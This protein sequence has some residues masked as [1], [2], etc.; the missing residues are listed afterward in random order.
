M[1]VI[2]LVYLF[3]YL[4]TFFL[5]TQESSIQTDYCFI[6]ARHEDVTN[7]VANMTQLPSSLTTRHVQLPDLFIS[8]AEKNH[9]TFLLNGTVDKEVLVAVISLLKR[10]NIFN[11]ISVKLI[12]NE[13]KSFDVHIEASLFPMVKMVNIH[14]FLL[15]KER[16]IALYGSHA[17][18]EFSPVQ[19]QKGIQALEQWFHAQGYYAV[20]IEDDITYVDKDQVQIDLSIRQGKQ[21]IVSA[22][23][24][25]IEGDLISAS[26]Q[27]LTQKLEKMVRRALKRTYYTQNR[28]DDYLETVRAYLNKQGYVY[29]Q[30]SYDLKPRYKTKAVDIQVQVNIYQTKRFALVGCSD[31]NRSYLLDTLKSFNAIGSIVPLAILSEE[32]SRFYKTRGYASPAITYYEEADVIYFVIDEG[33]PT[34]YCIA[35]T[36]FEDLLSEEYKSAILKLLP[37]E[38]TYHE[39]DTIKQQIITQLREYGFWQASCTHKTVHIH[40]ERNTIN[41]I[42]QSGEQRRINRISFTHF[43]EL[44]NTKLFSPFVSSSLMPLPINTVQEQAKYIDTYLRNKGYVYAKAK[45]MMVNDTE[46]EW[47]FEGFLEPV[48]FGKV[49]FEGRSTGIENCITKQL[50]FAE[51]NIWDSSLLY[52]SY[53]RLM[54]LDIFDEISLQPEDLQV[55]S[56]HKNC[57]IRYTL[58]KTYEARSRLG[59]LL[60]GQN[61]QYTTATIKLG[62]NF[63]WRNV[64]NRADHILINADYSRYKRDVVLRYYQPWFMDWSMQ[65][66]YELYS[67][68]YSQALTPGS[69]FN[70]YDLYQN[71]FLTACKIEREDWNVGIDLG[72]ETM[73]LQCISFELAQKINF[74]PRLVGKHVPYIFS[75][76]TLFGQRLD[77]KINPHSGY[78]GL[79]TAKTMCPLSLKDGAFLRVLGEIA[80]FIPLDTWTLAIRGRMGHIFYQSFPRI[81]PS[82]RFYLGGAFSLRGYLND[83]VPPVNYVDCL[84]EIVPV[85]VGGKSMINAN[86]ELR[87]PIYKMVTGALFTDVGLLSP[88]AWYQMRIS[89]VHG[90]TGAGIRLQTPIG[91]VRFD[92]ARKWRADVAGQGAW[93][94]YFTLGYPF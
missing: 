29:Y 44:K 30:I 51:N 54:T 42:I 66:A 20:R 28:L 4:C 86:F 10:K 93:Q 58:A 9:I 79:L 31:L 61:F 52:G 17:G 35:E 26:K 7:E 85:P 46:L 24:V 73:Q 75:E 38:C 53:K 88:T 6:F 14:G 25:H 48:R 1:S 81:M 18:Y 49:Y 47:T 62:G 55:P 71:G 45:P 92:V 68:R 84:G 21:Y 34:Q 77:N 36:L 16:L 8:P 15:G 78:Y 50:L 41:L 60:V 91:P 39:L 11:T 13:D 32:M 33:L 2:I 74:E 27:E 43:D 76:V 69:K 65:H 12:S 80:A 90:G 23:N 56:S 59:L 82:E 37:T 22:I 40:N 72:F 5:H 67:T 63:H 70:L 57:I 83:L 64:S 87:F 3:L 94:W 19:H 89:D